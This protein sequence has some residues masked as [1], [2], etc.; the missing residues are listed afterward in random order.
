MASISFEPHLRFGQC[1]SGRYQVFSSVRYEKVFS[2]MKAYDLAEDRSVYLFTL[3]QALFRDFSEALAKI[4]LQAERLRRLSNPF[5]LNILHVG[6]EEGL[7][8]CVEDRPRGACLARVLQDR[9]RR[10][11]PFSDREALG[12]CWLLCRGLEAAGESTVHGFLNPLEIYLEPWPG[13]PIAFYPRIAHIGVRAMLRAVRKPFEGL[14]G[15][16]ACYAS[17]EFEAYGPLGQQSDVYG[18]GAILYGMLTLRVPTGC[19]VRPGSVRP[20]LPEALDRTLLRALDE[21]PEERYAAPSGLAGALE[22]GWA[23]G[24][25]RQELKTAADRLSAGWRSEGVAVRVRNCP[26]GQGPLP[27]RRERPA[28]GSA[29]ASFVSDKVRA[30]CLVLLTL[31]NLGLVFLA[32]LEIGSFWS[33]GLCDSKACSKW[34]SRFTEIAGPGQSKHPTGKG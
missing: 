9:R 20:G 16:V 34:E 31:L 7:F 2:L 24:T 32:A 29:P 25:V 28:A 27:E 4:R 21:D 30:V 14:P 17:P 18:V 3:P 13:G 22:E 33:S 23:S 26:A 6:E 10:N 19:F 5:L 8:F 1:V 12:V 15:E 11:Q